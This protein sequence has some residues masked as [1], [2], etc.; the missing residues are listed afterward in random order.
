MLIVPGASG[1]P[2]LQRG[3]VTLTHEPVNLSHA[4]DHADVYL[5]NGGLHGVG[6]ALQKGCW[7]VLVPMQ[8]EQVA[9]A[10]NLVQRGWGSLWM[11][12]STNTSKKSVQALFE[13]RPRQ[14]RLQ[15]QLHTEEI[16]LQ[17]VGRLVLGTPIGA[18]PTGTGAHALR[19]HCAPRLG[20]AAE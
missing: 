3:S 9:M 20:A 14:P 10:R 5:S 17:M 12:N 6:L 18:H 13:K 1:N 2:P 7:P 8:S 15:P 16:L 19:V 11:A 4:F